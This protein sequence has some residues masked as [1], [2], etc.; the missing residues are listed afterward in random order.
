M[1]HASVS[2]ALLPCAALLLCAALA[3]CGSKSP[4]CD[5]EPVIRTTAAGV[6]YVRTPDA[7]FASLADWPYGPKYVEIDGLRQAYVDEGPSNGPVVL[8]LHGQPSWS[9]LYR[10]MIPV[11]VGAGFRVI[12]MDH[13]GMGRSDKPTEIASYSYLGH[14]DRLERFIQKLGLTDITLFCQD[15]GSLIG[16][17]V[18]GTNPGWFTR[19]AVGNGTLPVMP[20]NLQPYPPVQSPDEVNHTVTSPFKEMPAQQENF[21]DANC[22]LL[23]PRGDY[24]GAWINYAMKAAAFHA[25]E[26][27]EAMTWFPLS[28]AVKAAYDAPFPS[29]TYMAG[30]RCFPSLVNQVPGTT[31]QA[32]NGLKS[33]TKPFVTIW[34]ANDPGNLGQC[35]T[36]DTLICD[37]P[38]AAGQPHARLAQASHFLQDDQGAEIAARLV[39]FIKNDGAKTGNYT[40]NCTLPVAAD[41]TGTPCTDNTQCSAL[42]ASTC[43]NPSGTTGFCSVQGCTAGSCADSYLCCHSC[44]PAAAPMLPFTGSA[45]FHPNHTSQLT[46]MAGCTCN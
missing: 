39:S 30:P 46:G 29:R 8:L 27:L 10:K 11:L 20:A 35:R 5:S 45:C 42:T 14:I 38:G 9:Y 18:A 2:N 37:I 16:L 7:C 31:Q 44:N 26:V 3:G 15:W 24:F 21:Y 41:G 4:A 40:T 22:D 13:L 43:I 1:R 12:A 36:Q 32:Y 19:I 28:D 17:R 6:E 23:T 33:F 34:A 25:S